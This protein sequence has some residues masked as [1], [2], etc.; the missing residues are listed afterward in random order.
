ML[1]TPEVVY[2]PNCFRAADDI[3]APA[4]LA[5]AP[6]TADY[7]TLMPRMRTSGMVDLL[8]S[9]RGTLLGEVRAGPALIA[10]LREALSQYDILFPHPTCD[11]GEEP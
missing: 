3:E 8:I 1:P 2:I 5:Q 10:T 9:D 6:F 7:I 11:A 4:Q